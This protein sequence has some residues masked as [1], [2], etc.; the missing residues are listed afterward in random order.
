VTF[1]FLITSEIANIK[2][3]TNKNILITSEI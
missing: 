2:M 1:L 3:R